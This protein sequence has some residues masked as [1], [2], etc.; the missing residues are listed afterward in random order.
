MVLESQISF[1]EITL[2]SRSRAISAVQ[3]LFQIANF[4]T[5]GDFGNGFAPL[6]LHLS[7][8]NPTRLLGFC[9]KQK[10]KR[11]STER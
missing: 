9:C 4:G 5:F 2:M 7:A 3:P 11:N 6:C 1:F 8:R 10:A